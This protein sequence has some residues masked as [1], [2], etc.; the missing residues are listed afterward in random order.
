MGVT[1]GNNTTS[2]GFIKTFNNVPSSSQASGLKQP[3]LS[4]YMVSQQIV[5]RS[6]A[7]ASS[8][9]PSQNQ[10]HQPHQQTSSSFTGKLQLNN[11][12]NQILSSVQQQQS[13]QSATAAGGAD[14]AVVSTGN[15][16]RSIEKSSQ[17]QPMHHYQDQ[18][19]NSL[20]Q[21]STIKQ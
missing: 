2:S 15:A 9:P 8:L 7:T 10:L 4:P 5:N 16:L 6:S 1:M 18:N 14:S 11:K 13:A 12:T 20:H 3:S 19:Q 21:S 17:Q